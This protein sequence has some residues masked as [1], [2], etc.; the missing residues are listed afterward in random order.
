[1]LTYCEGPSTNRS[2]QVECRC[3][4]KHKTRCQPLR[5]TLRV[6]F[7]SRNAPEQDVYLTKLT[8]KQWKKKGKFLETQGPSH[9]QL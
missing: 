2:V 7:Q 5:G 3:S 6:S 4:W 9:N 1:M 8:K